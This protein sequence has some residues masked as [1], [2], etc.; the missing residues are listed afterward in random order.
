MLK[1]YIMLLNYLYCI[2][3]VLANIAAIPLVNRFGA[4]LAILF[5]GSVQIIVGWATARYGLFGLKEQIPTS[6]VMNYIGVAL[7]LGRLVSV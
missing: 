7:T 1:E 4:G 5:S 6:P 2:R 3:N